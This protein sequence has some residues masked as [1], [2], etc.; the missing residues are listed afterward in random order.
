[1]NAYGIGLAACLAAGPAIAQTAGDAIYR[2]NV[3]VSGT[4]GCSAI[5]TMQ[6]FPATL[7][8][9]SDEEGDKTY[10]LTTQI[11]STTNTLVLQNL[12]DVIK[13]NGDYY[14]FDPQLLET[15]DGVA[16]TYTGSIGPGATGTSGEETFDV[17]SD[18]TPVTLT[19]NVGSC[20]LTLQGT[21]YFTPD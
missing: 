3:L 5:G 17:G 11:Q 15:S 4:N 21:L 20:T 6:V 16:G 10:Y 2:G 14:A 12:L 7:S 19:S 18:A 9:T 8:Y 1:M 13:P